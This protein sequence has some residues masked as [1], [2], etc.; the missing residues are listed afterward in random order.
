MELTIRS[1]LSFCIAS[2][3]KPQSEEHDSHPATLSHTVVCSVGVGTLD[4]S[5]FS[6]WYVQPIQQL[7]RIRSGYR[8]MSCG[9]H[10]I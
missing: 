1:H 4:S 8:L 5:E 3:G 7:D 6:R 9:E 10:L 2:S